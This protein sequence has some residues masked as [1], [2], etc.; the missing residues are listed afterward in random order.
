MIAL[1]TA[2]G[3]KAD[4]AAPDAPAA[5]TETPAAE[6]EAPA[7]ETEAAEDDD[8]PYRDQGIKYMGGL[9]TDGESVDM[10]LALY[11]IDGVP[12]AIVTDGDQVYYGEYETED[13]KF[14]DGTE[15]TLIDIVGNRFGYIFNDDMSGFIIDN[16]DNKFNAKELDEATAME[17]M[18]MTDMGN[19]P[20]QDGSFVEEQAGKS[21]FKDYDEIISFLK[22]G[23]GYAKIK[24]TGDDNEVLIVTEEVFEADN[25]AYEGHLY[26]TVDGNIKYMGVVTGNG[27]AYPLRYED[28]ILYAG[29]NH[30]YE[31]YFISPEYHGLMVKD[32]V[33]DGV[34]DGSNEYIGFLRETNDYDHD[35]DFTGGAEEFQKMLEEREKKPIIVFTKIS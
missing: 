11:R 25:S 30:D 23:Q 27:S 8:T 16:D 2:C 7:A 28:G 29:D 32:S 31:S 24:L 34:N 1:L 18:D 12:V 15:F 6:T 4:T 5:E 21:S 3:S 20:V 33:V 19:E 35:K 10:K 22:P 17:M 13:T 9:V 14:D 26:N